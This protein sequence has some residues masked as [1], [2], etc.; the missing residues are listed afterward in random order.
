M[1]HDHTDHDTPDDGCPRCSRRGLLRTGLGVTAAAATVA[2]PGLALAGGAPAAATAALPNP[3]QGRPLPTPIPYINPEN[4]RAHLRPRPFQ[5]AV[6][7]RQLP[8]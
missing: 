6:Q 4:G 7:H 2:A 1:T 5:R 3:Y 8:G